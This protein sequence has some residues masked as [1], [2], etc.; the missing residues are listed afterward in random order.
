MLTN[1]YTDIGV[2]DIVSEIYRHQKYA[3]RSTGFDPDIVGKFLL[4][5]S[6]IL[7]YENKALLWVLNS[8]YT[9]VCTTDA[10]AEATGEIQKL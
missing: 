7:N 8:G 10:R 5:K 6:P 4:E 9:Y 1:G 2:T 3:R